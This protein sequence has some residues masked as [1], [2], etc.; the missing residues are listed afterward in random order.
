MLRYIVKRLATGVVLVLVVLTLIFLMLHAVPG[1]PAMQILAG[2][3]AA[4]V[5]PEALAQARERL[6][7]NEPLH[8]QYWN[9][10]TGALTGD[11]GTSFQESSSVMALIAD[12][13]PNTLELVLLA[14]LIALAIGIPLGSLAARRGGAIDS[15]VSVATSIGISVPVY[16]IGA[17]FVLLF[18]LSLG[19]LPAGG[20]KELTS[21]PAGHLLRLVLPALALSI[22]IS[23]II[24]RMTRSSILENSRQEWVRTARSWGIGERRVFRAHVQRNSLSPV[25]TATALQVG[26]LLGSTVL[27]ERIFNWPGLSALLIDSVVSRDYPVVQGIVITLSA[28]FIFINIVVD[29]MYGYLDPRARVS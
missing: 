4:E 9:Y 19:W 3:G 2:S 10:L 16:V 29:I 7:L 13:L 25:A 28:I 6:G 1:D 27:V 12:R 15:A 24:A 14:V 23:S 5:T 8:I 11:L 21:D 17:L 20:F 26:T 18:S 22:G